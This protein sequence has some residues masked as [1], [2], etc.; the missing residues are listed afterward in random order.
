MEGF[1]SFLVVF[2]LF[3]A[4]LLIKGKKAK[5][6]KKDD[7]YTEPKKY[8]SADTKSKSGGTPETFHASKQD[9]DGGET[10]K[11][12]KIM[13]YEPDRFRD[14]WVCRNC[15]SENSMSF[16]KCSVCNHHR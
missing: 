4:F 9:E 15:E 12:T 16:D 11:I 13:L 5:A 3:M 6:K 7:T 8:Y 2:A 1:I 10:H 14:V